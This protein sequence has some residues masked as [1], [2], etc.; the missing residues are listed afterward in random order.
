M[1][2]PQVVA[3]SVYRFE[4]SQ[5]LDQ[6]REQATILPMPIT[7]HRPVSLTG[8]V[9]TMPLGCGG[10]AERQRRR[11]DRPSWRGDQEL[12]IQ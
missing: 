12:S 11:L 7:R 8:W 10:E 5:S 3:A 6:S 4:S 9:I 1:V 2:F